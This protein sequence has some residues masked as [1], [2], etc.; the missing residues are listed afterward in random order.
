MEVGLLA[1][2]D[3]LD[4]PV[5]GTRLTPAQRHRQLVEEAVLAEACGF[6]S[7]ALGEHH[8]I[9]YILSA[10][11]VVLA[12]IAERTSTL[13]LSTGVAL[14]ANL[15]PV[16]IAEDYA[17]VDAL[18]GGRVEPCFGRGTFF[19]YVYEGFGQDEALAKERFAESVELVQRL[20]C[21]EE[22]T[23][24]GRFRPPLNRV[25]THPRPAQTPPPIWIGGGVSRDSVDL[26]ARLGCRLM[27]PTVFGSWSMFRP[28]VD[29]YRE[30]WAA[31]GHDPALARVGA[32]SHFFVARDS[33]DA[34]ARWAPRYQ[35]YLDNVAGWQR[36]S[37]EQA[38][39]AIGLFPLQDFETM[40]QTV[41][42]CGSP[43][44]VVDR[45]GQLH[46]Q[47]GIDTHLL[48]LDM[49]G[50]P[51]DELFAALELTGAEVIPAVA[52]L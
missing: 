8:F 30:Q 1:L 37:S 16:R 44:E 14:A 11:P 41:A 27:L 51:D 18:S 9:E 19:P 33:A 7:V 28:A 12:A 5:T 47:L 29:R 39:K 24:E 15:D 21:E 45:M 22:V 40:T 32:C 52:G 34:K 38:G 3:L 6:T 13:R 49:G 50:M 17:T 10:P 43:A 2:G 20:W 31:H 35:H 26:A 36:Q 42:I 4:D 25:T 46:E 23:W 48:M